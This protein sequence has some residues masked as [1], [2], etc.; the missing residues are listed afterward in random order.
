MFHEMRRKDKELPV[1]A[2]EEALRIGKYGVLATMSENGYPYVVPLNYAYVNRKIYFHSAVTG[3]KIE[4]AIRYEKVGFSVVTDYELLPEKFDSN[5]TSVT[6]FGRASEVFDD[7]K[8]AGLTGF[9]EKYSKDFLEEGKKYIERGFEGV[10][11][12][13]ITIDHVTGKYQK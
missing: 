10:R 6:V 3:E 2:M 5:Y 8:R 4:N 13:S 11:V 12:F 9:I 7:E 1:E